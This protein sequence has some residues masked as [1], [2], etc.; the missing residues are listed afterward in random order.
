M[1]ERDERQHR[2][3]RRE[4]DGAG[5][6]H[7]GLDDGVERSQSILLVAADLA[8]EDERVPHQ[9]SGQR[10]QTNQRID[11]ERLLKDQQGR[12]HADEAER[13]RREHHHHHRHRAH[14]EDDRDQRERDHDREQRRQ[15]AIRLAGLFDGTA[16]F[17]RVARR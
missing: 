13:R 17:N 6:L 15:R 14:L 5:A 2:G 10:D 7:G 16:L 3:D 11:T 9:D 1:R 4:N 12:H 8:D